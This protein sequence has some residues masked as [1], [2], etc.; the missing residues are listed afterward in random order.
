MTQISFPEGSWINYWDE[1]DI[2]QGG[3]KISKDYQL[4]QY[5]LF[6]RS[7]A[8]IPMNVDN[9]VT[10]HGSDSSKNYLTLLIY[11][12]GSSS[13][14]FYKDEFNSIEIKCDEINNGYNLASTEI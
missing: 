3:T 6:I 9:S 4:N 2:H 5:P 1:D 10:G 12:D 13:Y 14:Q 7:G 8:I 11:P